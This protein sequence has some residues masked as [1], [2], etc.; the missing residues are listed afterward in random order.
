MYDIVDIGCNLTHARFDHD[1]QAVLD[2]AEDAGVCGMILTGTSI[3][4]SQKA[5]QIA[6]NYPYFLY[7]TAGIHP[8]DAKEFGGEATIQTLRTLLN[9]K[10]VVAVGE[11]GLDFDRNFSTPKDQERCFQAQLDLAVEV[12]KPVFLHE[13]EAAP[14]FIEM[15]QPYA[16]RLNGAVVHCFTG[17]R[18]TLIKYIDMGVHIGI[19]GAI[20][21]PRFAHLRDLVQLI[22]LDKLMI[23][24]DAPFL[25][26]KDLRPRPADNRN[27]PAYLIHVLKTVAACM[28]KPVADVADATTENARLFFGLDN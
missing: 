2:R 5:A 11:C 22:P 21:D 17:T 3:R 16:T 20:C 23:E 27:E 9:Q 25:T 15:L 19:T 26:P 18:E 10:H 12:Q 8:H 4:H 7:S 28:G 6:A 14:R 1:R 24:T 13:R